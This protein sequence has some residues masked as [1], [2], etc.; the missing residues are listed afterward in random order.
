MENN[1]QMELYYPECMESKRKNEAVFP[2]VH[3]K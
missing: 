3:G 2:W 1:R